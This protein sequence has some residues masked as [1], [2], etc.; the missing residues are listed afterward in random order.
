MSAIQNDREL[1]WDEAIERESDFTLLE[2]GEYG[3]YIH[4]FE[5]ARHAGS[6]KLPA[7]NKAILSVVVEA[8]DGREVSLRHNLFLHTKCEGLLSAFFISIGHKKHGQPLKMNWGAVP[9]ARG[10][11]TVGIYEWETK[12]GKKMK[13]NRIVRFLE[14][15]GDG[16]DMRE[17]SDTAFEDIPF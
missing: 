16:A 2:D 10:R 12:D 13:S 9:G 3:F 6:E 15:A 5:R 11:C 1:G 14:P 8:A 17:V 7:C 4:S